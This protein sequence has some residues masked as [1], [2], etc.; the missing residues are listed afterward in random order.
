MGKEKTERKK[1]KVTI[2][3]KELPI[4]ERPYEKLEIY[5]E[6]TLTN[7]EL[8]AII[9]KNG[10]KNDTSVE[11]AKRILKLNENIDKDN[12]SFL[13]DISIEELEQIKG[14]G[15][16]KAIQLKAV[17]E[18]ARR[19]NK[20]IDYRKKQIKEPKDIVQAIEGEMKYLKNEVLKVIILNSNNEILKIKEVFVGGTNFIEVSTKNIL[21]EAVK[22]QAPKIILAHNHPSGNSEPSKK[23]I[24]Y[25]KNIEEASKILGIQLLD[26]II[27]AQDT[28][29]SIFAYRDKKDLK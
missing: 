11:L 29:T 25:T 15:R 28:Y 16:V 24:E 13:M 8:L 3:I 22:M 27:I 7:A 4:S 6:N 17:C 18:L 20:P 19:I 21:S 23:D 2:K 10:T 12:L 5:G 1:E 26:H 9:I 14:I